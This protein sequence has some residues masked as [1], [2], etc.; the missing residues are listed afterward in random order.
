M[1]DLSLAFDLTGRCQLN[2]IHC[3]KK[4]MD[5]KANLPLE[6][7]KGVLPQAIK[8]GVKKLGFSG[9][10]P[11]LHPHLFEILDIACEKGLTFYF[12]SNGW[13]F[14][15]I[16]PTL[17][18]YRKGVGTLFFSLDGAREETHDFHRAPGSYQRLMEAFRICQEEK[19][20]FAIQSV[21]TARSCP[22]IADICLL[23]GRVG[24]RSLRFLDLKPTPQTV[25]LGLDLP[26]QKYIEIGAEVNRLARA[27]RFPVVMATGAHSMSYWFPCTAQHMEEFS[28]DVRGNL[29]LCLNLTDYAGGVPGTEVAGNL[30]E[31]SF[32]EA[33]RRLVRLIAAFQEA[34]ATA[35]ETGA[36]D[37][38]DLHFPCWSCAKYFQK[39][40]WL[41]DFPGHPW[42]S[43]ID[44]SGLAVANRS[45]SEFQESLATRK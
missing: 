10:E 1:Q 45:I 16:W 37:E 43:N 31:M 25:Q 22:E 23:A 19:V 13:N 24:S 5:R 42:N 7:F 2:C 8:Y 3:A 27:F 33:H 14:S 40:D 38:R 4:G 28:V 41:A 20:P 39:M 12:V 34:K 21:V 29:A 15:E 11:T 17:S 6:V 9:G 44:M 18:D 35:I 36:L 26:P 30:A 32:A